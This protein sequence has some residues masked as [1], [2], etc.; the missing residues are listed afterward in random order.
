M[1]IKC[2]LTILQVPLLARAQIIIYR[3]KQNSLIT[4]TVF[5]TIAAG[6]TPI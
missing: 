4:E 1:M 3:S 6:K 2:A 5:L